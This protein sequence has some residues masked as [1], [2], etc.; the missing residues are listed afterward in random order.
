M[1]SA[2][3]HHDLSGQLRTYKLKTKQGTPKRAFNVTDYNRA[4]SDEGVTTLLNSLYRKRIK[5][6]DQDVE[7]I[8]SPE[9]DAKEV[10]RSLFKVAQAF[11]LI[12]EGFIMQCIGR[13]KFEGILKAKNADFTKPALGRYEMLSG[14]IK[15]P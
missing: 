8:L 1:L 5:S 2:T 14:R 4:G 10:Y 6:N 3:R 7:S 9:L 15:K 13:S 12:H 11:N